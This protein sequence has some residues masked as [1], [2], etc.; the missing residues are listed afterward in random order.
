LPFAHRC[1]VTGP[2][3]CQRRCS[4]NW[5]LLASWQCQ[6]ASRCPWL[7]DHFFYR[8]ISASAC[9]KA[10]RALK[11]LRGLVKLQALVRGNIVRRQAAETLRCMHA[12]VRVQARARACRAILS[13]HTV[14]HPVCDHHRPALASF[15]CKFRSGKMLHILRFLD[16]H[17]RDRRRRRSTN[18][19]LTTLRPGTAVQVL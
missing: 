5:W 2:G 19:W 12:L 7:R 9:V 4:S 17:C 18:G 11:A 3:W 1:S 15:T 6:A 14:S 13:Q 10:R 8:L 16:L